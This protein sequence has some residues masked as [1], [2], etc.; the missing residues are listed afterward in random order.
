M[1]SWNVRGLKHF[2]N[3]S[4]IKDYLS[5]FDIIGLV[6]TW[7]NFTGEYST[8]IDNYTVFDFIR[9]KTHYSVRSSGGVCVFVK[10]ELLKNNFVRRVCHALKDCVVLYINCGIFDCM[11]DVLLIVTYVSPERSSIYKADQSNGILL[12][13][14]TIEHLRHVF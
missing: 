11:K 2:S 5:S 12:L 14:Q 6:E 1:I 8:F 9:S 4:S 10:D 3:C 7:C 13:G